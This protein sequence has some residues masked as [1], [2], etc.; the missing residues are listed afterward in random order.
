M[1]AA[2]AA[3]LWCERE[4]VK[5]AT[6][7][8]ASRV[9]HVAMVKHRIRRH[10]CGMDYKIAEIADALDCH[11]STVIYSRDLPPEALVVPA[12]RAPRG[13]TTCPNCGY[14]NHRKPLSA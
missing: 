9:A 5:L 2:E 7:R 13:C 6:V 8:S 14:P 4:G 3:Q 1:S 12:Y 11:Y 10:L